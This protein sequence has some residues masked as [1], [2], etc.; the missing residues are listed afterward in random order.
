MPGTY[1]PLRY[2]GGKTKLSTFLIQVMQ[3]NCLTYPIYIEPYAGG[4]GAAL[5][6]LFEEFVEEVIINDADPRIRA[7]WGAVTR[8]P[9]R[10]VSYLQDTPLSVEEWRKQRE[11]YNRR[12][13]RRP[14][15]LGFA[16]FYLNRTT[17]SGIIHN[18]GPIGG[19][20]QKG[21]Y[22][23]D[24]RFNRVELARRICR[25]GAYADRIQVSG[26]DGLSLLR[27]LNRRS[28]ASRTLVYIDPPYYAK[29]NELYLNQLTHK[30]HAKLANY[31]RSEKNFN[32]LMTYDDVEQVRHLYAGYSKIPFS[33]SY[34]AHRRKTGN[35][36]LIY[37]A[38][39]AIPER[40]KASLPAVAA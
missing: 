7:F 11:I 12:D 34:S 1:S 13:L 30:E 24:A 37:P 5:R 2:P 26:D 10:F 29:G 21:N 33:L 4:A 35:E 15:D 16:T 23:I 3:A 27:N 20:D 36:L 40:A 18:G 39:V 8:Q 9:N 22:K 17:R 6:L 38:N 14:F 25:I 31:L 32:W 19:F 28:S